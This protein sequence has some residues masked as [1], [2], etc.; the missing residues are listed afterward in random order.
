MSDPTIVIPGTETPPATSAE[1]TALAMEVGATQEKV[2]QAEE[3]AA[4][5]TATAATAVEAASTAVAVAT[6]PQPEYVTHD[7]L[8]A[9]EDRLLNG[10]RE[11][12]TPPE[13]PPPPPPPEKTPD[14]APKSREKVVKKRS[15]ADKFYGRSP[16]ALENE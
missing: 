15:L 7:E 8:Q 4:A 1:T 16:K 3:E 14:T 5:A 9:Q 11:L 6:A 13:P 2:K 12:L 10:I